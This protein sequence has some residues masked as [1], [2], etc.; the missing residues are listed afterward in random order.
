M[1]LIYEII[2]MPRHHPIRWHL[3]FRCHW[4]LLAHAFPLSVAWFGLEIM[5]TMRPKL[6]LQQ[7]THCHTATRY[8]TLRLQLGFRRQINSLTAYTPSADAVILFLIS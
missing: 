7:H 8:H 5:I 6:S 1:K 4:T 3:F 2:H